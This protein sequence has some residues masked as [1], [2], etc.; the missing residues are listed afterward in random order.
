MISVFILPPLLSYIRHQTRLFHQKPPFVKSHI[1]VLLYNLTLAD[2]HCTAVLLADRQHYSIVEFL[3]DFI[4][5][6]FGRAVRTEACLQFFSSG[7]L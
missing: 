7:C 6:V 1:E 3:D 2:K 4:L 5:G